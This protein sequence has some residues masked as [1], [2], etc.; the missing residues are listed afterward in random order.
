MVEASVAIQVL[1]KVDDTKE[2]IRIVD[3]VIEYIASTGFKYFVGP[4]ETTIEGDYDALMDIVK[5]CHKICILEGAG[6]VSGYV[7]V[8]YNPK[9]VL[10]IGEKVDKYN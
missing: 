6:S 8:S 9:G 10:T 3:K 5:E 7:K 2:V 1:P 4:F